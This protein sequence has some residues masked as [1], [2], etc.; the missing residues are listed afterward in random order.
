[1]E[2]R[3]IGWRGFNQYRAPGLPVKNG[4]SCLMT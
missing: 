4:K 3:R 1:M 2:A